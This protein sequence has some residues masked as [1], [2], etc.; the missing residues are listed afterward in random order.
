MPLK[1]KAKELKAKGWVSWVIHRPTMPKPKV[2]EQLK[3]A[4]SV[5]EVRRAARGIGQ[6]RSA[7][8]S[9]TEWTQNPAGALLKHAKGFLAAKKLLTYP[10]SERPKSDDKRVVLLAKAMAGLTL[11]LAP[12]TARKRL[13]HWSWPRDWAERVMKGIPVTER[14]GDR[15]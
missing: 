2:W 10:R 1:L 11:G 9:S 15:T 4:R 13:S 3:K 7:F 12:I 8:L 6:L 14:K 5:A